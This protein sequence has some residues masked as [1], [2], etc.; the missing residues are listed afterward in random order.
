MKKATCSPHPRVEKSNVLLHKRICIIN[1]Q[2][3]KF[4]CSLYIYKISMREYERDLG[5]IQGD[6]AVLL[7]QHILI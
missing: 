5:F 3:L 1:D 2:F 6:F 7:L 4:N